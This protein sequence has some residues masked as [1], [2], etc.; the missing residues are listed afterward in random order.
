VNP[1]RKARHNNLGS[2]VS[3]L[4]LLVFLAPS[5]SLADA[6][7]AP[8]KAFTIEGITE[9]RLENGLRILLFPDPSTSTV[10]VNLTVFV[11]SRHEGYG[12][13]GMAHLLEHMLFKGTPL[14]PRIPQA[15]RD[16]GARYNGTTSFDRT[17]YYETMPAG[18]TN[19]EFGIRLE[20]DRLVNSYVKREDLM[21]EMTVVRNEFEM[22][23][24]SP[25][26]ILGQ[27][28]LA[29][30]YEWH[31][32]G[33][34]TIGNRSDI[35]RVPIDRLQA[36]YRK[37]YQPDNALLIVAGRFD[38]GKA[39][40]Y[41]A[42]Y[43]AV[44]ERP[45]RR[46]DETYTEEPTQDG[47]RTVVLRR[48][49]AVG[50]VGAVYHIPAGSHEDFPAIEVLAN[51]LASEPS[52]R[53][54]RDLVASKKA[55]RV[56]AQ[57]LGLHDPGVLAFVVDVEAHKPLEPV[58]DTLLDV[59]ERLKTADITSEEV[60]RATRRLLKNR[61]L[62]MTQSDHVGV[63]LS[64]WAAQGDWRLFFLHRDR[65]AKVTPADVMRVAGRYLQQSNRTVG[66]FIATQ[67]PQRAAIPANPSVAQL[68]K[69]YKGGQTVAA[70]EA[71]DP[72]PANIEARVQYSQL[73]GGVKVA[74][75][76]K[77]TRGEAVVVELTLRYG[78]E[79]SLKGQNTA[80]QMLGAL[81]MRGTKKHTRQQLQD[82]LDK[83]KARIFP[84]GSV[85]EL[86]FAIQCRRE[87]LPA[88]LRLLGE[89]LHEPTFPSEE[90]DVLR[91]QHK[92]QLEQAGNEPTALAQVVLRRELNPYPADD[93][94]YEPTIDEE[95]ARLETLTVEQ[96]RRF[97]T[98]QVGAQAGEFVVVGDFDPVAVKELAQEL[99]KDWKSAVPYKHIVR[100]VRTGVPG[101]RQ[102]VLTPDKANAV[103]VAGHLLPM[104]D[105]DPDDAAL[106]L[107]NFI[108]GGGAM[109]S[110]LANRVRQKEGLS[111]AIGS[112]FNAR[113]KDHY[114]QL[115]LYAICNPANI[116]KVDRA[117]AQELDKFVKEGIGAKELDEARKG[118]LQQF[119]VQRANDLSLA[120]L[121]GEGLDAARTFT[122]YADLE[123]RIAELTPDEINAAVRRHF[124]PQRLVIVRAGDFKKKG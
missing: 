88:V 14:H 25:Q 78:N 72:T 122:Y 12:E 97:Y 45:A 34:S 123:K 70:G 31:N 49:G 120:G 58:R 63:E 55:S 80:A 24:N 10:T 99:L 59:L 26:M 47:E 60:E 21:S 42:R 17:N 95:I 75:L 5:L 11:G 124:A 104:I 103:Y 65:I 116:D 37:H 39:L 13:T 4:V 38:Q 48:V 2:R 7:A 36:F 3:W 20:A 113:S 32:Y 62:L 79:Q 108:L 54:Y 85:G 71:F 22:G 50:A 51:L 15:L 102:D 92:Q 73:P 84:G 57:A 33:K 1:D 27:R 66:M 23:E 109:A 96:V 112:S 8:K 19:L 18:D 61:E 53:L 30:A 69:D 77:K 44:L 41:I 35:E 64:N 90:L 81:M 101:G 67:E 76:P 93:V 29:A 86:E 105:T 6:P 117:I 91:R 106:E 68:L 107:A 115:V 82:D 100:Q 119:K 114:A 43:F 74:L 9:Y 110:R 40:E 118:F 87:S 52:G 121:L 98:E 28:M 56:S 111:Y 46:L 94:R 16:H 89:V 83:L